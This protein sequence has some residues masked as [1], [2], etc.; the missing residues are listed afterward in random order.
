MFDRTH[1][2][3]NTHELLVIA[4]G[5]GKL[6]FGGEENPERVEIDVSKGDAILVPAG[7]GHRQLRVS[8]DFEM[9]GSYPAGIRSWDLHYG[10]EGDA[11]AEDRIR[12]LGW[13]EEDPIYAGDG[14][15]LSE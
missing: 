5:H 7:V 8:T 3:S 6:L 12:K 11:E 2:H 4:S 15:A 9:V 10:Q 1:Y 14:P 13:F